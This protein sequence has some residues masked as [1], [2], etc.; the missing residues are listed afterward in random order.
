MRLAGL[1]AFA[2][3]LLIQVSDLWVLADNLTGT[4]TSNSTLIPKVLGLIGWV[5]LHGGLVG[6]YVR[7]SEST[8]LLGL[9]GFVLAFVGTAPLSGVYWY[10]IFVE[11]TLLKEAPRLLQTGD[12]ELMRFGFEALGRLT[13]L[14]WLIFGAATYQAGVYPRT[15]AVLIMVG[16]VP[17]GLSLP[18]AVNVVWSV[19]FNV[20]VAWLGYSLLSRR[21]ENAQ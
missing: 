4:G 14:G 13:A 15:A 2:G 8:G 9:T 7:Q 19:P 20:A 10:L 1:A 6:L 21:S 16:A 17:L 11:P 12:A 3:G 5:L 18:T